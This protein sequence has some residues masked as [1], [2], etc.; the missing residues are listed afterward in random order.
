M[1]EGAAE[2]EGEEMVDLVH[3][4]FE[5]PRVVEGAGRADVMPSEA[6][7]PDERTPAASRERSA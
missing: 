1:G 7:E 6:A 3:Q 4:L 2:G 5:L